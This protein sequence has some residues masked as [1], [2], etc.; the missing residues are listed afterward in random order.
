LAGKLPRQPSLQGSIEMIHVGPLGWRGNC[1]ANR[2]CEVL[3]RRS[4][5]ARS[6][7][8]ERPPPTFATVMPSPHGYARSRRHAQPSRLRRFEEA[9]QRP[10]CAATGPTSTHGRA[11]AFYRRSTKA[12]SVGGEL[13][14]PTF[15]TRFYRDDPRRPAG[16]AGKLPGQPPLQGSI[17]TIHV[18]PLGWRGNCPASPRYQVQRNEAW[19]TR[20]ASRETARL[21]VA[22]RFY[23][24]DL[25]WPARLAVNCHRQPSLPGS[26][27]TIHGGPLGWR[28]NC[29]ASLRYRVPGRRAALTARR[30]EHDPARPPTAQPQ[31]PQTS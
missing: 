24:D 20:S 30:F 8:G 27:E 25:R 29:P 14:P 21:A 16:L 2:R 10:A 15:A 12:R 11:T 28:G 1:P 9:R 7:G 13:P 22:T 23:Q 6:V 18:G 3:S 4:T 19:Q 31:P 5:K 17:E 26:I